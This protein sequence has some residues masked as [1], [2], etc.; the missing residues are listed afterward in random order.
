MSFRFLSRI[1]IRCAL[2]INTVRPSLIA[3]ILLDYCG[4]DVIGNILVV[5]LDLAS[6]RVKVDLA[7]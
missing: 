6:R 2:F 7:H 1:L 4:R 5:L 3:L